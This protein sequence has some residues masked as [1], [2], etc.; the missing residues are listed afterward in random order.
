MVGKEITLFLKDG[1]RE[2][3]YCYS[4]RLGIDKGVAAMFFVTKANQVYVVPLEKI[5]KYIERHVWFFNEPPQT[6]IA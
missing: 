1:N 6:P 4:F 5:S 2:A 3:I